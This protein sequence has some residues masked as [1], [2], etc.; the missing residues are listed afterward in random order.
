MLR[1]DTV[2]EEEGYVVVSYFE[3]ISPVCKLVVRMREGNRMERENLFYFKKDF[4]LD[5][6][7]AHLSHF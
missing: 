7:S 3:L 5:R 6:L 4:C 2:T 1:Q